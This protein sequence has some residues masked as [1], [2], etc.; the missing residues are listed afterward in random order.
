M[1]VCCSTTLDINSGGL[2]R[3][4]LSR[5]ILSGAQGRKVCRN[6]GCATG[7]DWGQ[8]AWNAERSNTTRGTKRR[9]RQTLAVRTT[10]QRLALPTVRFKQAVGSLMCV[11][12]QVFLQT[13]L[14][15]VAAQPSE[16]LGFVGLKGSN[17]RCSSPRDRSP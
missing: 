17:V 6:G 12:A 2:L 10:A 9:C 11:W 5:R 15:L 14:G 16:P 13:S 4:Q 7:G 8:A 3:G 1:Y